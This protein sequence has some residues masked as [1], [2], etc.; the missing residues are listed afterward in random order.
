MIKSRH[1]TFR[2]TQLDYDC[3]KYAANENDVSVSELIIHCF[4]N[5]YHL[6]SGKQEEK[7]PDEQIKYAFATVSAVDFSGTPRD[8]AFEDND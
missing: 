1:V 2:C 4:F 5:W 6:G 8:D 7:S 3:I